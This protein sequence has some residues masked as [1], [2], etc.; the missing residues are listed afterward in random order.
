MLALVDDLGVRLVILDVG[1]EQVLPGSDDVLD[2]RLLEVLGTKDVIDGETD[3]ATVGGLPACNLLCSLG[4]VS[5]GGDNG[6]ALAAEFKGDGSEVL[7]GGLHDDTTDLGAAGVDDVVEALFE[8]DGGLFDGAV[9]DGDDGGV[10][11]FLDEA[12]EDLGG[13]LR[14][15]GGLEDHGV[16]GCESACQWL[17]HQHDCYIGREMVKGIKTRTRHDVKGKKNE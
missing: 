9:D 16:A 12:G 3:L 11:V 1:T 8:Q 17:Q 7:C 10:H 5:L 6:G 4:D 13:V 2:Q 14:V 15:L